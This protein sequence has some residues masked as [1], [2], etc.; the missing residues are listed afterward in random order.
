ML[1]RYNMFMGFPQLTDNEFREK[2]IHMIVHAE[3][4]GY[5]PKQMP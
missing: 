2:F 5:I 3:K 4:F 1:Y